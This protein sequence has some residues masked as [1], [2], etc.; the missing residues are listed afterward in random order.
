MERYVAFAGIQGNGNVA[1][2]CNLKEAKKFENETENS[3]MINSRE[4]LSKKFRSDNDEGHR[5]CLCESGEIQ[6]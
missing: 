6:T 1:S 2:F 3:R 5:Y 4:K